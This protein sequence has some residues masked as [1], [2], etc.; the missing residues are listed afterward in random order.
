MSPVIGS[1]YD[2]TWRHSLSSMRSGGEGSGRERQRIIWSSIRQDDCCRTN[3]AGPIWEVL[4]LR[5]RCRCAALRLYPTTCQTAHSHP[6]RDLPE[7]P[8]RTLAYHPQYMVVRG[9][10]LDEWGKLFNERQLLALTTF[11]RLVDEA[12]AAMASVESR[13]SIAPQ[14][15]PILG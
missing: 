1:S 13:K 15:L 10:G 8:G 9:Y 2:I 3:L 14:S 5:L 7:V 12:H 6:L 4:P 11:A